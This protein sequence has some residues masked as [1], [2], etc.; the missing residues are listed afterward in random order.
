MVVLIFSIIFLTPYSLR[1]YL[2]IIFIIYLMFMGI[3]TY[4]KRKKIDWKFTKKWTAIIGFISLIDV[5]LTTYGFKINPEFIKI[6]TN[7]IPVFLYNNLG[8]F[9]P[10]IGWI[11]NVIVI[12]T[13]MSLISGHWKNQKYFRYMFIFFLSFAIINNLFIIFG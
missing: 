11:F 13:F 10:F 7:Q 6:E 5:S 3:F 1:P 9:G 4:R 8:I 12:M 2:S